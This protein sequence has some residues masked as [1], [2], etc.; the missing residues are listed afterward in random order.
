MYS[1]TISNYCCFFIADSDTME[2]AGFIF[3]FKFKKQGRLNSLGRNSSTKRNS[4][5]NYS[6]YWDLLDNRIWPVQFELQ[7]VCQKSLSRSTRKVQEEKKKDFAE[8]LLYCLAFKLIWNLKAFC[9]VTWGRVLFGSGKARWKGRWE[10]KR[11]QGRLKVP[12]SV[13]PVRIMFHKYV[14]MTRQ[15]GLFV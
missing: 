13:N 12:V 6:K 2:K 7:I 9:N 15:M 11:N 14:L 1:Y 3:Y 4:L 8:V 10:G 5:K